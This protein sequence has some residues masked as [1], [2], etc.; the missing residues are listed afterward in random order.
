[1]KV[2]RKEQRKKLEREILKNSLEAVPG[3]HELIIILDHL[4]AGY[5]IAK[6][7]RTAEIFSIKKIFVVGTKEFN[8][9][10]AKGAIRRVPFEF[11]DSLEDVINELNSNLSIDIFVLDTKTNGYL[12]NT[13]LPKNCAFIF[14]NEET[15]P[16]LN[17]S[18]RKIV[19]KIKIKQY[20]K[21]DS[22]NVS[23][24]ASIACYEYV[25]QNGDS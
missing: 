25:R 19:K 20:G 1:M 2:T 22:L 12:H 23:V 18:V 5:N 9:F 8:P 16:L 15:G 6:I 14:G 10:P 17:E 21:T 24:A 11:R 3:V 13:H 7:F 4:K